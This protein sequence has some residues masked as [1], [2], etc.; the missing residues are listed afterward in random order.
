MQSRFFKAALILFL[1]LAAGGGAWFVLQDPEA[2]VRLGN[3]DMKSGE[4]RPE[5]YQ[6]ANLTDRAGPKPQLAQ[7]NSFA[8]TVYL[9][10]SP[11]G[12]DCWTYDIT[13]DQAALSLAARVSFACPQGDIVEALRVIF[14]D[15]RAQVIF[16]ADNGRVQRRFEKTV[17]LEP[18]TSDQIRETAG[19]AL[20][21]DW[22]GPRLGQGGNVQSANITLRQAVLVEGRCQLDPT[23]RTQSFQV[24][25]LLSVID[26]A[27]TLP[28]Q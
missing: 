23:P 28:A 14:P 16:D 10:H 12:S 4:V 3:P 6:D 8:S 18:W 25:S 27:W 13:E 1:C 24:D 7:K 2:L 9:E 19:Q 20:G 15:G 26:T 21:G 11:C 17:M 5:G 22:Q